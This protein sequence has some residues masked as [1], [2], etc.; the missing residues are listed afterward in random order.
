LSAWLKK[1]TSYPVATYFHLS[2]LPG[3]YEPPK[4]LRAISGGR[5]WESASSFRAAGVDGKLVDRLELWG[6]QYLAVSSLFQY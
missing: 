6:S 2:Q 4:E 5:V 1:C 3:S